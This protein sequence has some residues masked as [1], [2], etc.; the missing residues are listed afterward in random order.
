M[1]KLWS[2]MGEKE[3]NKASQVPK[4]RQTFLEIWKVGFI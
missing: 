3:G 2:F 4:V 1:R